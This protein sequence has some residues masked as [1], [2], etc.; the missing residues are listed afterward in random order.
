MKKVNLNLYR[1]FC[2][3]ALFLGHYTAYFSEYGSVVIWGAVWM[4]FILSGFLSGFSL[5]KRTAWEYYKSRMIRILPTYY[6]ALLIIIVY[7][8]IAT[9]FSKSV[10]SIKF[11]R[12]IFCIN[13]W[14][15]S[16][17]FDLWNNYLGVWTVSVTMFFYLL[18]PLLHRFINS[19]A[20][21]AVAAIV[22]IILSPHLEFFL[23]DYLPVIYPPVSQLDNF[24][25]S[26]AVTNLS[27][28]IYG[29]L[30]YY[31]VKENKE[32]I[33]FMIITA[34]I[35]ATCFRFDHEEL[36]YTS[37]LMVVA[38]LPPA[39]KNDRIAKVIDRLSIGTYPFY[40]FHLPILQ[41]ASTFLNRIGIKGG[42]I[43]G[44][45]LLLSAIVGSFLLYK[46][47]VVPIENFV[48]RTFLNH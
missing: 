31:A 44:V 27:Y 39:I 6:V 10:F 22:A 20:R 32:T 2:A 18:A 19:F 21:C 26:C 12:F 33:C 29:M 36:Y 43:Y 11:F 34:I 46:L 15:P 23:T 7:R 9:G 41:V 38:V 42:P 37:V 30:I 24:V 1:I 3:F 8:F 25:S 35:I 47:V 14:F 17:D 13:M 5:E 40:L 16:D 48:K 28:F 4:F 45:L